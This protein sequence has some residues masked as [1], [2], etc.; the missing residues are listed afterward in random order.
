[1]GV[2]GACAGLSFVSEEVRKH[3]VPGADEPTSF[4]VPGGDGASVCAGSER[5]EKRKSSVVQLFFWAW[6]PPRNGKRA[7]AA[8]TG[9]VLMQRDQQ[10]G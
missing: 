9:L 4:S 2:D 7:L 6:L 10:I 8:H 5:P 1:M 3:Q